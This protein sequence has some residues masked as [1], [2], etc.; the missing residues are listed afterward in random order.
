MKPTG[1]P[2]APHSSMVPTV[3][4]VA[5]CFE[6]PQRD[7]KNQNKCTSFLHKLTKYPN[8]HNEAKCKNIPKIF[9]K[10]YYLHIK[11]STHIILKYNKSE[12]K[13]KKIRKKCP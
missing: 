5:L 1:Q 2:K 13:I 10:N 8:T 11:D 3:Q 12:V 7:K 4:Q 9:L 6:K